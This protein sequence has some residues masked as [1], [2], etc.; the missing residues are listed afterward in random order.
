[1]LKILLYILI[2]ILYVIFRLS[3]LKGLNWR[4]F[5]ILNIL[6]IWKW[7][8]KKVKILWA[9]KLKEDYDKKM[10]FKEAFY[11]RLYIFP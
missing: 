4:F 6:I 1:M 11:V 5:P 7:I 2:N 8:F 3:F 10:F 9:W